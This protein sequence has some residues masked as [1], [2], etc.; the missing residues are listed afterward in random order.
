MWSAAQPA[1]GLDSTWLV[2]RERWRPLFTRPFER[3]VKE[4]EDDVTFEILGIRSPDGRHTLDVDGYQYIEPEG[5]ELQ[6]GGDP[7]SQCSL[8]DHHAGREAVLAQCGTSG[9]FHWGTWLTRESFALSGWRDADEYGQWKQAR[10]WIYSIPDSSVSEYE[11]RIVSE[12]DY[13]RYASAWHQ[14]LLKR[15]RAT[16]KSAALA[17]AQ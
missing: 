16:K 5:D 9:G 17:G 2:G 3:P 13:D 4:G 1:F 12:A 8:I 6:V 11:T 14:W 7:D 15:Y 10:L